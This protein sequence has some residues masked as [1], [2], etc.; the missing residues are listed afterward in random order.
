[1]SN[2]IVKAHPGQEI[3]SLLQNLE[4]RY[5]VLKNPSLDT[6]LSYLNAVTA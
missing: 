1:M 4:I 6:I 2:C 3:L 5:R